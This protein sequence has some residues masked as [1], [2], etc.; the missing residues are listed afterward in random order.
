MW[1]DIMWWVAVAVA[2]YLMVRLF[3]NVDRAAVSLREEQVEGI[4]AAHRLEKGPFYLFVWD[5]RTISM[6]RAN[7]LR[8]MLHARGIDS[9][10]MRV[11]PGT[12]PLVYDLKQPVD[13]MKGI[14]T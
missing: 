11:R 8:C 6:A 2:I 10:C 3:Q 7:D 5:I 4:I 13:P 9:G 14:T 1:S 12:P